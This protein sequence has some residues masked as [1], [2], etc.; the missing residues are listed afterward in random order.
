MFVRLKE[1]KQSGGGD[2]SSPPPPPGAGPDSP[3]PFDHFSPSG[4]DKKPLSMPVE[5]P[6]RR[7][8]LQR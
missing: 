2:A 7:E 8:V 6:D 1:L 5:T 3:N 4:G